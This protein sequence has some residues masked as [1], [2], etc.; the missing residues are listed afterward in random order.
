MK[1]RL[2]VTPDEKAAEQMDW[3]QVVLNGGAPCFHVCED[4]KFCGRAERWHLREDAHKFRPLHEMLKDQFDL[5]VNEA[6]KQTH[7]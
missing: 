2:T 1:D 4:N 3:I 7:D 5:G 6:L